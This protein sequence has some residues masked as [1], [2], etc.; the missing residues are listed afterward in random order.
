MAKKIEIERGKKKKK[1]STKGMH[2]KYL[3]HELATTYMIAL[4]VLLET[5]GLLAV[6]T[7]LMPC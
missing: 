7:S 4:T 6:A 3:M 5:H 2:A 1:K